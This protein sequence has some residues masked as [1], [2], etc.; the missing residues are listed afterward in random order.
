M[1]THLVRVCKEQEELKN[2]QQEIKDFTQ[3]IFRKNYKAI[4]TA[5][6]RELVKEKLLEMLELP[7]NFLVSVDS[8]WRSD[9]PQKVSY[10][11]NIMMKTKMMERKKSVILFAEYREITSLKESAALEVSKFLHQLPELRL[12]VTLLAEVEKFL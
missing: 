10:F 6:M 2:E 1:F 9:T 11:I 5:L 12:P 8:M 3:D 4:T 7:E